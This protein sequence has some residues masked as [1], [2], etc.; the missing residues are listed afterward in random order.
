MFIT[1]SKTPGVVAILAID[2]LVREFLFEGHLN[3]LLRIGKCMDVH[4]VGLLADAVAKIDDDE[5]RAWVAWLLQV[6]PAHAVQL[7]NVHLLRGDAD[8]R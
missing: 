7:I 3:H 1:P 5:L 6:G 8:D 4:E 2:R